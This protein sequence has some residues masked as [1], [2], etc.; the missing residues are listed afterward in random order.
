MALARIRQSARLRLFEGLRERYAMITASW[1]VGDNAYV[2]AS[3]GSED[4][5]RKFL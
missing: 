4:D 1:T 5:L 2:L 3:T